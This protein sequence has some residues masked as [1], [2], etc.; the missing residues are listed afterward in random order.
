MKSDQVDAALTQKFVQDGQRLVFWHDEA[1]EFADYVS[2]GLPEALSD[3]TVVDV[4]SAGGLPTKVLLERQDPTGQF[5]LYSSGAVLA[6]D[7][8]LLLDIRLYSAT[9]RAD[10][11]SLWA[12][13]FGLVDSS[14]Q[15]HLRSRDRF[16]ASQERRRKLKRFLAPVETPETLDR[17]MLAVLVDSPTTDF[18]D[19]LRAVCNSHVSGGR[20]SVKTEPDALGLFEKMSLIGSFWAEVEAEFSFAEPEPT[21]AGLLRRI[22]VS[23]FS[24]S[25]SPTTVESL[26]HFVLPAAGKRNA[27]VFL[28][29]WRDSNA[30]A[31]AYDAVAAALAKELDL[32]TTVKQVPLTDLRNSF[33]FWDV[34]MAVASLLKRQVLDEVDAPNLDAVTALAGHRQAG[35]WLSQADNA[36]RSALSDAYSAIVAASAIFTLRRFH[37]Q[38]L[39]FETAEELLEAYQT[40]LFKFDQSYRSFILRSRPAQARGWDLLKALTERVEAVYENGFL[41]PLGVE[42]SRL[43]DAGFLNTWHSGRFVAQQDFYTQSVKPHL[44]ESGRKRAYVIISDALR[45]EAAQELHQRLQGEYRIDAELDAMLGVVPSY[46]ALGMASLLPHHELDYSA[47]GDVLVDGKSSTGTPARNAHLSAAVEGMACQ[48]SDLLPMTTAQ[49]R[50]F[51]D[52]S[53]VIYIYHN[54]IDARGDNAATENQ[55]FEAVEQC[56]E[57]ITDLVK[58]CMNKLNAAKVWVTADHGFLYQQEPPSSVDRSG[59]G[60]IPEHVVKSKKRYVIGDNLGDAPQAHLGSTTVTAGMGRGMDFWVPRG[61]NRFHFVG[62]AKFVHGGAMPQEVVVPVLAVTQLRG[63]KAAGSRSQPVSVTVLGANHK[64]TTP[65]YGFEVLQTEPVGERRE[66]AT[67]RAAVYD[68][69]VAVTSIDTVVLDSESDSVSDRTKRIRLELKATEYDK[70]K[71]YRLVLRDAGTDAEVFTV[72]VVIDRSFDDDF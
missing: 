68:G 42:W 43:L 36:D 20:F 51:T 22:F 10:M 29:Q 9:F 16:L 30:S 14:L 72:P 17:K 53:R 45:Y 19:V 38:N 48:A 54:V 13:E 21:L 11:A 23:E 67:L 46:T 4:N 7:Q 27:V 24:Q 71:P 60:H 39:K 28:T 64:I 55:T 2:D 59:L 57:E 56:L 26:A 41:Q 47:S 33:T 3:V 6:P 15:D 61:A 69:Q 58:L 25:I 52:G 63:S 44:N 31:V 62:G 70:S 37:E 8:D 65:V 49:A 50:D 35:P 5:L 18:G 12:D 66:A 32:E 40:E 1:G 34:E